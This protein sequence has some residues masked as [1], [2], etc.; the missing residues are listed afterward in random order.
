MTADTVKIHILRYNSSRDMFSAYHVSCYDRHAHFTY[1]IIF[2]Q[3]IEPIEP[4]MCLEPTFGGFFFGSDNFYFVDLA[5]N[6]PKPLALAEAHVADYPIEIM[7]ISSN[8]VLLAY[9]SKFKI[10]FKR[11]RVTFSFFRLR[12]VRKLWR[13]A[14][15]TANNRM[16][17]TTDGVRYEPFKIQ[18]D[19]FISAYTAPYLFVI[20]YDSIEIMKVADF[21]GSDSEYG[22]SSTDLYWTFWSSGHIII[23]VIE[24]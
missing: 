11:I 15:K 2:L 6:P 4:A 22:F 12:R 16:G 21:R 10:H 17:A 5:H 9:Q 19:S 18:N 13:P 14:D 3:S 1:V 7:Q 20:H 24:L 23:W 8:E